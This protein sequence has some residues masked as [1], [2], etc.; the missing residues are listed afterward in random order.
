MKRR[1]LI[2]AALCVC[3]TACGTNA[4]ISTAQQPDNQVAEQTAPAAFTCKVIVMD[5]NG[6]TLTVKPVDVSWELSSS[7]IFTL[8]AQLLDEDVTPTIGMTLEITYDGSILETYPA[9]FSGIQ[10]VAVVSEAP[11]VSDTPLSSSGTLKNNLEYEI[12]AGDSYAT[13][14]K[15][16]G[17][18]IN[19]VDNKYQYIICSGEHSTGGYG[20]EITR[21]DTLDVGTVI[22]TVEETTPSPDEAVTEAFTYPN[23]SITFS[24]EPP[25][26]IRIKNSTGTEYECLGHSFAGIDD[27][28]Q[29]YDESGS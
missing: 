4:D 5:I 17:Y 23:C 2:T 15:Q 12:A 10:K 21:I 7:D 8:S 26:G 20:I 6:N 1:L 16:R 24:Y 28:F 27:V 29:P 14:Y 22:I 13:Q 19:D 11:I 25:E 3:L 9:S 18:Y